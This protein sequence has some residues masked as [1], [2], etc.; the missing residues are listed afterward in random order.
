MKLQTN[1]LKFRQL[2]TAD[3]SNVHH[4]HSLPETD[5]FNTLGIPKSI[6]E[7]ENIIDDW[8]VGQNAKPQTS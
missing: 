4:L 6:Q 3:L 1:R 5:E 8:L 2:S 7:T